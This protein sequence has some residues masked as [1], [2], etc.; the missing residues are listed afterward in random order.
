MMPSFARVSTFALCLTGA[1]T[2]VFSASAQTAYYTNSGSEYAVVGTMPGDQVFPDVAVN[3]NGGF[4]VWQDN[5]ADGDSLGIRARWLDSNLAS[6]YDAFTV[7]VQST[8]DQENPRVALLKSGG[9]VFVWQ[10]GL[11]GAQ[12]IYARFLTPTNTFVTN[13]D[14]LVGNVTNFQAN[15]A[16]AVL[17]NSNV[18]VV[19]SSFDRY[20]TNTYFDVFGKVLSPAG[21]TVR[22]DFLINQFTAY[23]QRTPSVAALKEGGFVVTWVSE[24]QR[25]LSPVLETNSIAV[26]TVNLSTTASVEIYARLYQESGAA[27]GNEFVVGTRAN[28]RANPNVVAGSATGFMVAWSELDLF[29]QTNGWDVYASSYSSTGTAG[30]VVRLNTYSYGAQYAPRLSSIGNNY[31]AVW[32]SLAQDGSREGV[33]GQFLTS[34]AVLV[35]DEFRVNTAAIGSQM[36]PVVASDG[37]K[38][39]MVVW[40]GLSGNTY[41]FDLFAQNYLD[42]SAMLNPMAAPFVNAPFTL[43]NDQ[44]QPQ[45]HVSWP[46]LS[47]R[48]IAVSNYEVYVDYASQPTLVLT[49]NQWLMTAAN[50]L[51]LSQSH[52]FQV[53]YV[54]IDG[55]RSP[56][57]AAATGTTWSGQKWGSI[58][59]EWMS[60]YFGNDAQKWPSSTS[61]SDG[62]GMSNAQEFLAGT[63]PTNSASVLV[64]QLKA[65]SQGPYVEW[66]TMPGLTYQVQSTTNFASWINLGLPRFAAGTTDKLEVGGGT[67][68]YYRVMLLRQ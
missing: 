55:K 46:D 56:I 10:G 45:L 65:N 31:L 20:G 27:N 61:D 22:N 15:P 8:G 19:W 35:G 50:G 68:G 11:P 28:P 5:I 13:G 36:H 40:A 62:D 14:L 25:V 34:D 1:L 9:A 57:S 37:V 58:P 21:V 24:Q 32:T 33:Y 67:A 66:P 48:G 7:N 60:M 16:V 18:V 51:G 2:A 59:Y 38:Q 47:L 17:N 4:V 26:D 6:P 39:F 63:N 42:V 41:N 12:H 3:T 54:R 49:N 53:D 52:V 43:S 23:N 30:K 44:Y 29:S 64:V